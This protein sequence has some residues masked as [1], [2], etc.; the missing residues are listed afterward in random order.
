MGCRKQWEQKSPWGWDRHSVADRYRHAPSRM[1][2]WAKEFKQALNLNRDEASP[3]TPTQ[4]DLAV[5]FCRATSGCGWPAGPNPCFPTDF[6]Q[7]PGHSCCWRG[8]FSPCPLLISPFSLFTPV[9]FLYSQQIYKFLGL[10]PCPHLSGSW[11][12][13]QCGPDDTGPWNVS[14][15]E[16]GP[17]LFW[18]LSGPSA[19]GLAQSRGSARV[20]HLI[21]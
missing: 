16:Q 11:L 10:R 14:S 15:W 18:W 2:S 12:G 8:R 7:E 17:P 9:C 1:L 5:P 20:C 19:A 3:P 4:Q 13:L 21:G 6:C